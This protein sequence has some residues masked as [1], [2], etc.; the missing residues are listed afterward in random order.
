MISMTVSLFDDQKHESQRALAIVQS[1]TAKKWHLTRH[2][3][4][5]HFADE[6]TEVQRW[7]M[8]GPRSQ[9]ESVVAPALTQLSWRVATTVA[10]R[11]LYPWEAQGQAGPRGTQHQRRGA[12]G[13]C[14]FHSPTSRDLHSSLKKY[15][16]VKRRDTGTVNP[17]PFHR[18]PALE[19][20]SGHAK[21]TGSS[22]IWEGVCG[23]PGQHGAGLE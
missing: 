5:S 20:L 3:V 7:G 4:C 19:P 12:A 16:I 10:S 13:G 17:L 11:K 2:S 22:P 8:T 15:S 23:C 9:N 21:G 14:N 1:C 18:L 6:Q